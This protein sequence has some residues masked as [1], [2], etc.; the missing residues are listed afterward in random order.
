MSDMQKAKITSEMQNACECEGEQCSVVLMEMEMEPLCKT[1]T[2]C[3]FFRACKSSISISIFQIH[4][5]RA[6][7]VHHCIILYHVCV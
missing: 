1:D 4:M 5:V 7:V 6:P 3:A 2:I